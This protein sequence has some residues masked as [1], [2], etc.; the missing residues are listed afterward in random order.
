MQAATPD[1]TRCPL[2]G[3]VNRCAMEVER[4]TGAKQPPCWCTQVDF[5]EELLSRVPPQARRTA[6]ICASCARGLPAA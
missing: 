1:P 5:S 6:C 2:C 4:E 3:Q